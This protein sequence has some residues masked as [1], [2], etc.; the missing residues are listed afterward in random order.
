MPKPNLLTKILLAVVIVAG[1]AAFL[2][3]RQSVDDRLGYCQTPQ[4][5]CINREGFAV[6]EPCECHGMGGGVFG[7][8][9]TGKVIPRP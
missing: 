9:S 4:Q 2:W 7:L 3:W 5:T 6:G 8:D 1:F